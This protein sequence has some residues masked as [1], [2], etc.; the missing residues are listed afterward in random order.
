MRT[1]PLSQRGQLGREAA[2][3]PGAGAAVHEVLAQ[4]DAASVAAWTAGAGG[5]AAAHEVLAQADAA[6]A[7]GPGAGAAVHKVLAQADAASVA[8]WTAG[9]GGGA[10]AHEV[11]A[12]ADAATDVFGQVGRG[13]ALSSGALSRATPLG[14]RRALPSVGL[15]FPLGYQRWAGEAACPQPPLFGLGGDS[16]SSSSGSDMMGSGSGVALAGSSESSDATSVT[17]HLAWRGR[18]LLRRRDVV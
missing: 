7:A 4:A 11:L 12:Q 6:T 9:A 10:A 15:A 13:S 5:G 17:R 1:P 16:S 3:G 8:A 18:P 14:A 2:A